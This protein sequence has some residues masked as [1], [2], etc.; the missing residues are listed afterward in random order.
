MWGITLMKKRINLH[1]ILMTFMAII[2]TVIMS[3]AVFYGVLKKEVLVDLRNYAEIIADSDAWGMVSAPEDV[4]ANR[5]KI[6]DSYNASLR[7]TLVDKDGKAL[8][9]TYAN[10]DDMENHRARPEVASAFESGEGSAIRNSSTMQKSVF[11]Y[12]VL[13]DNGC[14][15]RV[16]K[17]V[18]NMTGLMIKALP[19]VIVL[20]CVL[21]IIC[22][23]LS[24]IL[25]RSIVEP[26][27]QL[28]DNLDSSES[29]KVYKELVP[30]VNTIRRQHTDIMKNATMRQEFTANV[31]HELKTPLT[32]ISGY[33]EL[34]ESGMAT[35]D[36][37]IRF[38]A[39]I[40]KSAKRLLTL[41]NDIIRLSE[42]DGTS[43]TD[44]YEAVDIYEIA[45]S[46]VEMLKPNAQKNNVDISIEGSSQTVYA[47]HQM[48]EELVY[49]LCDN[50]IRYN[51]TDGK[52][53]VR[54][55]QRM[56]T[57]SQNTGDGAAN[58]YKAVVLEVEDTGIGIS[59]ENKDRIFERFYRVDK[60]RSKL[61]GGTGLG[62]AIVKHIV[63]KHPAAHL[64]LDS[65]L[66][67]GTTI[68]VVF[69]I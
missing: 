10:V 39:N 28:A 37:V 54:V 5:D 40:H 69:K 35:D 50:A 21:F 38:A 51:K 18:G 65:K 34:I 42:L 14:V 16:S 58:E 48:M 63:A 56:M 46:C 44:V 49:N 17:E 27:E 59:D 6:E 11:Y 57:D 15:L 7:I 13:L 12:A 45:S 20:C 2:A 8:L 41:I 24:R 29:I 31:S 19:T 9:D 62:L 53:Y 68:R 64:E 55:C 52:V 66:G 1:F 30:F 33:S 32:S 36:D 67:Q 60:S 61:T 25:T 3:T 23:I 47:N 26:I 4:S 22:I 43:E